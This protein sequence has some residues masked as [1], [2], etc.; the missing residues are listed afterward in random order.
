VSQYTP[1]PFL[2]GS[3]EFT[4]ADAYAY[5]VLSWSGYLGLTLPKELVA[6]SAAVKALPAVAKTHALVSGG[7]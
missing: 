4:V 7:Q 5:I 2:G 1:G 6:Y 3:A